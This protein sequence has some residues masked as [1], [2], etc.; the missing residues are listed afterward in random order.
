MCNC[1]NIG[2]GTFGQPNQNRTVV[3]TC[4]VKRQEIDNCIFEE[5]QILWAC[6][7]LTEASCCGHNKINGCIIVDD[8]E[9]A[10]RM[11][12]WGYVEYSNHTGWFY[13]K[14]I[15]ITNKFEIQQ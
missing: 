14:S 8:H 2:F 7:I 3:D 13:P 5:L 11:R 9:S 4:Y 10:R 6:K 15:P 1:N 12:V